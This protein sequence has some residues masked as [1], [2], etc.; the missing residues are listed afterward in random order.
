MSRNDINEAEIIIDLLHREH[1][2]LLEADVQTLDEITSEK[3][4]WAESIPQIRHAL[5]P[6]VLNKIRTISTQNAK[7]FEATLAAQRSVIERLQEIQKAQQTL[8]TYTKDGF[9]E[10]DQTSKIETRS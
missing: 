1:S 3:E 10:A 4:E 8:G 5:A 6:K 7:L 2:A 9:F